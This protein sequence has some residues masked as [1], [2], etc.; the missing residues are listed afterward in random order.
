MRPYLMLSIALLILLPSSDCEEVAY[1]FDDQ[2]GH[3]AAEA[4]ITE[5][6]GNES[7]SFTVAAGPG[8]ASVGTGGASVNRRSQKTIDSIK[9][10]INQ[11]IDRGNQ[12]VR[13]EGLN[14]VGSRSGARRI[15]QICSVYDY[16]VENW[17]FV[18]DWRGLEQLQY[19]NY[20]L[21]KGFD[22]GSSGKG[23]CDDFSILLASLIE[24]IGG[25]PRL[26]L[27]Y[28]PGGGHAYAEVY[29]GKMGD[30]DR[31]LNRMIRWLKSE[32]EVD[33]IN[34]HTDQ[35][36]GDVWL[37]LDWWK[38]PGGAK[39]PGGPFFQADKHIPIYIQE[40]IAKTPLTPI[41]NLNPQAVI[42]I[43]PLQP[44][45]G[46][47][48]NFNASQSHDPDGKIALYEWSFGD[49]DIA[50][51][52]SKSA[53]P[54]IYLESGKFQVNLTVTDNEGD[55]GFKTLKVNVTEPLPE[56]IAT[57]SPAEPK[58]NDVVTFDA[59]QSKD[60]RGRIVECEW[61]FDDGYYGK[62]SS[63]PHEYYKSGI[64][65]VSLTV[66]NDKGIK[67]SSIIVVVIGPKDEQKSDDGYH[68]GP[69]QFDD[70]GAALFTI[71]EQ[72]PSTIEGAYKNTNPIIAGAPVPATSASLQIS[73]QSGSLETASD[74]ENTKMKLANVRSKLKGIST[75]SPTSQKDLHSNESHLAPVFPD[76]QIY[77]LRGGN[78]NVLVSLFAAIRNPVFGED[79]KEILKLDL[80]LSGADNATYEL[81]DSDNNIYRPIKYETISPGWQLVSFYIPKDE[82]FKLIKVIPTTGAPFDIKWWTTPKASNGNVIMRYYGITDWLFNAYK[83]SFVVKFG[84]SNNG[85]S[86][87]IVNYN[88]FALLDQQGNIY[89]P[90]LDEKEILDPQE[91]TRIHVEFTDIPLSS[92]LMA[93]S[94][95]YGTPEQIIIDMGKDQGQLTDAMVYG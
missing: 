76:I 59:T 25:T 42:N 77:P 6:D 71:A 53:C 85:T 28:G 83:Q 26:M 3:P 18:D 35:D 70:N 80:S 46:M 15:D 31:D 24:S 90:L 92:K 5:Y 62:R 94:Y 1:V 57:Y 2:G 19:S 7:V 88:K 38:D 75:D 20:T 47:V 39:H 30:Q 64:Y 48:V 66:T 93:V 82:L 45:M 37:N 29:L 27:A 36:S 23:D 21:R 79:T 11:R 84:I 67:N 87:L 50:K 86:D 63:I 8:G 54:H 56:P 13:D 61:D 17:T 34:T 41:E 16:M 89:R 95:D 69:E 68:F 74:S 52:A 60:N 49:G 4:N 40:D 58:V 81:K 14:L 78:G 72:S 32:Y 43:M 91:G 10:E 33:E 44:E 9:E 55:T 22:A 65:N 12:L 73:P 51:G